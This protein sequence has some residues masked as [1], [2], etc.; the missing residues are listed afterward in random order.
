MA[1]TLVNGLAATWVLALVW[2][3]LDLAWRWVTEPG[4]TDAA[5]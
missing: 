5:E 1:A 2:L 4:D 3:T